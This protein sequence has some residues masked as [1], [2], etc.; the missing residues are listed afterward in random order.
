MGVSGC[1]K[2][3]IGLA[4]AQRLGLAFLEGDSFHLPE[5]IRAMA[6]GVALDDAMRLPW[7]LVVAGQLHAWAAGTVASCSALRHS[8][9]R[10]SARAG[11]G[12][13][14]SPRP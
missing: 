10:R 9:R 6:V 5:N 13:L 8:Y 12:L 1:G 14:Y 2:S 11:D 7:L 3:T 4:L